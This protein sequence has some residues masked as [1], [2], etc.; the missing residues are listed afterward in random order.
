MPPRCSPRA[1]SSASTRRSTPRPGHG[2]ASALRAHAP[3]LLAREH[4]ARRDRRTPTICLPH[5][6]VEY[7][8]APD[9]TS[10]PVEPVPADSPLLGHPKVILTPHAA[11]F[12]VQSEVELRRKAA[13]NI[14]SW[15]ENGRPDYVV[16]DRLAAAGEVTAEEEG[17]GGGDDQ[18]RAQALRRR[19]T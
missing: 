19:R 12:S 1:T 4:G 2:R 6:I 9:W 16:V 8:P 5:S 13:Q 17:S 10:L 3:G 14:V 11:F 18:R 15:L 7:L